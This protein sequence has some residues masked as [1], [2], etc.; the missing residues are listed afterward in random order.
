METT[1]TQCERCLTWRPKIRSPIQTRVCVCNH[2]TDEEAKAVR[3]MNQA[4][5]SIDT[6]HRAME[7]LNKGGAK[8]CTDQRTCLQCERYGRF[9]TSDPDVPVCPIK[10]VDARDKNGV[11]FTALRQS[12]GCS[13]FK[14]KAPTQET[15]KCCSTCPNYD[16]GHWRCG[17]RIMYHD[18]LRPYIEEVRSQLHAED[19]YPPGGAYLATAIEKVR[20][21]LKKILGRV[22]NEAGRRERA[23][24]SN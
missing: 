10:F 22:K 8:E 24:G 13:L 14:A 7:T 3:E 18:T 16:W 23:C 6:L 20:R 2:W 21:D 12:F 15:T 19:V 9:P 11:Y 17:R 5:R 4:E 1:L